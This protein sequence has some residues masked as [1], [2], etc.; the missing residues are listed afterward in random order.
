MTNHEHHLVVSRH[1][2]VVISGSPDTAREAWLILHGY[3]MLARGM[4]HWFRG[5]ERADRIMVAPEGLSRFYVERDAG[6]RTVGASWTTR[7]DLAHELEDQHAFLERVV[8]E[9]VP[10][11]L[12]LHVHGFSQGVSVATRWVANTARPI[13]RLV[14]WAGAIPADVP[15]D[16][17]T[18]QLI[19]E[20]LHLVVGDA[21]TRVLPAQVEADE[22]R[23]RDAGVPVE[24]HRF[25][26][27]H[28]VDR[29]LLAR[30][31]GTPSSPS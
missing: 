4:M 22:H 8:A 19:D 28:T 21:D 13:Q 31:A 25:A 20:P 7:E 16:G 10:S 9:L 12:P 29:G 30:F 2:R 27:G 11:P 24:L 26:G 3:A 18:R 6:Y 17:L 23:L 15:V 5:A 1:A 14:C